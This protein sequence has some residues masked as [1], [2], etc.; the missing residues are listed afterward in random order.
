MDLDIEKF[1][2]HINH[3]LLMARVARKVK[4]K[5]ILK[6]IRLYLQSGVMV[7]GV[8]TL[9]RN[10]DNLIGVLLFLL[11]DAL[12]HI[13]GRNIVVDGGWSYSYT[14]MRSFLE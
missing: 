12:K 3:G 8:K 13:T 11:S 6:L 2:D 5:R 1:F 9:I 7:K 10:V 4:D 14:A